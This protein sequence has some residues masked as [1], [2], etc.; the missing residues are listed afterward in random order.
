MTM[1]RETLKQYAEFGVRERLREIQRELE[2]LARDFPHI[3]RNAD[4]SL[5]SVIPITAKPGRPR[6]RFVLEPDQPTRPAPAARAA[7]SSPHTPRADDLDRARRYLAAHPGAATV[8]IYRAAGHRG[9]ASTHFRQILRAIARP[10]QRGT[11]MHWTLKDAP[12]AN[13]NGHQAPTV[14]PKRER[15]AQAPAKKQPGPFS[16]KHK[17]QRA[18]SAALLAKYDPETPRP[19]TILGHAA[20]VMVR[21]GYLAKKDDGYIR[22]AKP[23]EI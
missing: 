22:T 15:R 17:A 16:A 14:V 19:S 21:R 7:H 13:G 18:K 2:T 4:G 20:G 12:A 6:E 8:E 10:E 11:R 1:N 5:P 23:F 9:N 3:V